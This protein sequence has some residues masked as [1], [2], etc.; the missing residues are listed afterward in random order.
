MTL[1]TKDNCDKCDFVKKQFDLAALGVTVEQ[2]GPDNADA[3]AH[4][5]WHGLVTVAEKQLPIL[6]MNDSNHIAGAIPIK[7]YLSTITC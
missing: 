5:A 6:V 7:K 2:L 3:L 4:L 1:F